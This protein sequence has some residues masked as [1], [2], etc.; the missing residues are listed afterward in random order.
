V[1]SFDAVQLARH[2]A[3]M[4]STLWSVFCCG[5]AWLSGYSA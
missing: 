1:L 5:D 4:M 3:P 2:R